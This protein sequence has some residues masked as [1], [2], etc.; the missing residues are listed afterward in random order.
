MPN[1]VHQSSSVQKTLLWSVQR[2][3]KGAVTLEL[4]LGMW[5]N[6]RAGA[7]HSWTSSNSLILANINSL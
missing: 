5:S 3:S 2:H 7:K 6:G 4:A 1:C